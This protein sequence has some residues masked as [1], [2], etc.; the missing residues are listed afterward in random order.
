VKDYAFY[1]YRSRHSNTD[2]FER[3]TGEQLRQS[4]TV[5]AVFAYNAAMRDGKIPGRPR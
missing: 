2:F 4:A 5:L 1:D 3:V